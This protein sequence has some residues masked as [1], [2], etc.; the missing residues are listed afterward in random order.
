MYADDDERYYLFEALFLPVGIALNVVGI[1]FGIIG[2]LTN[3]KLKLY[4]SE[5]YY[6]NRWKILLST[7]GLSMPMMMRGSFN[8]SQY[9]KPEWSDWL[10]VNHYMEY[11]FFNFI[12][13][14]FTPLCF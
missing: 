1:T 8:I 14:D 2:I 10:Q 7:Y 4:F 13:F 3:L 5:F 12:L 9:F 11:V 6:E